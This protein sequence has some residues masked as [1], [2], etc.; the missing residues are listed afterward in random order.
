MHS[1]GAIGLWF[2]FTA[3][4]IE[5]PFKMP[6]KFILKVLKQISRWKGKE[7][8]AERS[9]DLNIYWTSYM[10]T[11]KQMLRLHQTHIYTDPEILVGWFAGSWQLAASKTGHPR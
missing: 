1:S 6:R 10:M 4:D 3:T 8:K 11:S 2:D 7:E 5:K 9:I